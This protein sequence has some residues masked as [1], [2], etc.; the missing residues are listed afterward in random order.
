MMYIDIPASDIDSLNYSV[1]TL[2]E[3]PNTHMY[4]QNVIYRSFDKMLLTSPPY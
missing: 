2:C 1:F 4:N 3:I